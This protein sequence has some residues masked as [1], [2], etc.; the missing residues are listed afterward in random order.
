[1]GV[2]DTGAKQRRS[3]FHRQAPDTPPGPDDALRVCIGP[4]CRDRPR[5]ERLF[6]SSSPFVRLCPSCAAAVTQVAGDVREARF[7]T[8]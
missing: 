4:Y 5:A 7:E 3:G 6:M 2:T 8:E 1:M